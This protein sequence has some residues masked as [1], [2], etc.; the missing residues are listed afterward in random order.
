MGGPR[1]SGSATVPV[2][3]NTPREEARP[4]ENLIF[5]GEGPGEVIQVPGD[6]LSGLFG[7]DTSPTPEIDFNRSRQDLPTAQR[8]QLLARAE[9]S[10]YRSSAHHDGTS[11]YIRIHDR[12]G[13][14]PQDVASALGVRGLAQSRDGGWFGTTTVRETQSAR[15][16]LISVAVRIVPETGGRTGY[17]V[18]TRRVPE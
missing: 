3:T 6:Q 10:D 2:R 8:V 7:G 13:L 1:N 5:P 15:S 14:T 9:G 17:R 18:Y 11:P 12:P 4:T 16:S